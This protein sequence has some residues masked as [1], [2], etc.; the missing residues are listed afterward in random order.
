MCLLLNA[1]IRSYMH[2]QE[3]WAHPISQYSPQMYT[4]IECVQCEYSGMVELSSLR[5]SVIDSQHERI[6]EVIEHIPV[7][8]VPR[9]EAY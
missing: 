4:E 2:I 9:F 7:D 8:H 5:S 3:V 1:L 6:L